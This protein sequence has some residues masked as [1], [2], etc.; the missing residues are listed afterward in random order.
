[1]ADNDALDRALAFGAKMDWITPAWMFFTDAMGWTRPT[2][3]PRDLQYEAF[4]ILKTHGIKPGTTLLIDNHIDVSI[5]AR[6]H[7]YAEYLLNKHLG[8]ENR[9]TWLGH[10][11]GYSRPVK[12]HS[13]RKRR[14]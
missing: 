9:L 3:I 11:M 2:K 7:R 1:M 14:R 13:R 12:R 5:P 10:L 4:V 6:Q 8:I